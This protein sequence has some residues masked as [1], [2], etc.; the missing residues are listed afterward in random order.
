[1]RFSKTWPAVAGLMGALT[2][3]PAFSAVNAAD[4][5]VSASNGDNAAALERAF[6][7]GRGQEVILPSGTI[8]YSRQVRADSVQIRGSGTVLAPSNPQNQRIFLT[9]NSPSISDVQFAFQ[10]ARRNGGNG[11][12]AA[13]WVENATNFTVTGLDLDGAAYGTPPQGMGGGN[14]FVRNSQGGEISDNNISYALADSIHITGGSRNIEVTDNQV[15]HSLD[16]SIAV[17][18]YQ[19]GTGGVQISDNTVTDN[20]WGRG[21]TAVGASDVQIQDNV[22]SGNSANLAGIYVASEASYHTAAP[23]NVL[24]EGNVVQGTGGPGPGHGQIMLFSGNGPL[25]D[26]TVRDNEIRDSKRGDLALVVSGPMNNVSVDGN[27]IDGEI[28]RR[29]GGSYG[30]GGN[31]TNDSSMANSVSVPAG[32][33]GSSGN[34]NAGT[35]NAELL[36]NVEFTPP[37]SGCASSAALSNAMAAAGAIASIWS[38]GRATAPLQIAQQIQLVAQRI[39]LQEQLLAALKNLQATPLNTASDIQNAMARLR[40]VLGMTDATIYNQSQAVGAYRGQYPETMGSMS[41]RDVID[42]TS[43]WRGAAHRAIEESWT[44]Q[45][46]VVQGQAATQARVGQQLDAVQTAPG[47]LAAQQGT[48]QLVGTLIGETQAMQ[49]VTISH[50]RA[51]ENTLAQQQAKEERAEELHRRAM[52]NLG[53]NTR[54]TVRSPF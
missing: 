52:E 40:S 16:D 22:V 33:G 44:L 46:G 49:N 12:L 4:Y 15:D 3:G 45:S 1:M 39:C 7:A 51:V 19:D 13:V 54:I 21:I 27:R 11:A 50:Y 38:S 26:V 42:Q 18:N 14:I 2:A 8:R 31:S 43:R 34:G 29:D 48:A 25:S 41:T 9:G 47:M 53:V 37:T 10:P 24:V 30:G 17:V 32:S 6:T 5:G 20:L 36:S 35:R 28:S 23:R